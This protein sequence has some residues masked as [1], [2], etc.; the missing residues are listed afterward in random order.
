MMRLMN[1]RFFLPA[2]AIGATVLGASAAQAQD[3]T[4]I[5]LGT[6]APQGTSYHHILQEM[7]ENWKTATKGQVQLTV[8]AGTMGSE[9]E[10]VRRMR[11]GQLQAATLTTTGIGSIDPAAV[12]LQQ[13]PMMF[14]SLEEVD[15]VRTK[16][17]PTLAKRLADKGY[18]VLF[19]ADAGWVR[20]FTRQPA[21]H[22]DDLKKLK[23]FVTAGETQQFDIMKSNG[24]APVS[25]EWADALTSLQTKMIDAVPTI[26]YMALSMQV[27]TVAKYMLDL[28]WVPLVG[29]TIISK[30]TW[31]ALS[32]ENQAAMRTVAAKSGAD[33]QARGRAESNEAVQAMKARGMS[34]VDIPT[35]AQAEW[36]AMSEKLYPR[37]RGSIVPADMFD[38]VVRILTEY[39]SGRGRGDAR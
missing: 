16:L 1:A 14:R 6:L 39:R 18:V 32:P 21:V 26:P 8:Y 27:H 24:F 38:D 33:F 7:G 19:W 22:P 29:A 35:A 23:I 2:L 5:R 25:L 13:M 20:Y 4:R 9:E 30:K 10:L 17:E 28:N 15:Y 34:L 36:R 31:D 12:A 3:V 11:L 37:I